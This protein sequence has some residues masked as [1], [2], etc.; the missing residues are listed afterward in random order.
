VVSISKKNAKINKSLANKN[1]I[2]IIFV[3]NKIIN[4]LIK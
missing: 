1:I 4:Y 2:K 3:K